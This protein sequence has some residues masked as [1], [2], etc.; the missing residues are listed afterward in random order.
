VIRVRDNGP[1]IAP[2]ELPR[3]F[4]RFHKGANSRGSGLGLSIAKKLVLAHGGAIDVESAEGAGTT[5]TVS[6]PR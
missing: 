6:L 5:V 1:G 2:D 4:D 3:L